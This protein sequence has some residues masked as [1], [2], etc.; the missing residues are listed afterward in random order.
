MLRILFSIFAF[1]FPGQPCFPI[2][3]PINGNKNCSGYAT[4]DSCDFYCLP[5]YELTGSK[6]RTCGP[7][8]E[9]TGNNTKCESKN[10]YFTYNVLGNVS[11]R[12]I[13]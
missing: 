12:V 4:E 13:T 10:L 11:I 1:G 6:R 9:W 5:G 2:Y 3:K 8:K 7:D